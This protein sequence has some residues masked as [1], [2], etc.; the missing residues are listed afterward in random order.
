MC[1]VGWLILAFFS[2]SF[3]KPQCFLKSATVFPLTVFPNALLNTNRFCLQDSAFN[4]PGTKQEA[5]DFAM[6]IPLEIKESLHDISEMTK[7]LQAHVAEY[8]AVATM[9]QQYELM[10][11]SRRTN[12]IIVWLTI[13][14]IVLAVVQVIPSVAKLTDGNTPSEDAQQDTPADAKKRR[15]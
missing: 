11:Q 3:C 2:Y 10:E 1:N 9:K 8:V 4:H 6:Q 15:G 12:G 7:S 14:V 13:A 5:S